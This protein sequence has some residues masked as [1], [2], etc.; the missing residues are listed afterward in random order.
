LR[1][2]RTAACKLIVFIAPSIPDNIVPYTTGITPSTRLGRDRQH[3]LALFLPLSSLG[4]PRPRVA[5]P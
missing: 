4:M 3:K 5:H 2:E 1:W